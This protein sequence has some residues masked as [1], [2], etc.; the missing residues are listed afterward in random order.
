MFFARAPPVLP[1]LV[2]SLRV[3]PL[4]NP[5]TSLLRQTP[6]PAESRLPPSERQQRND[7]LCFT[8][9]WRAAYFREGTT[10]GQPG[11]PYVHVLI[12]VQFHH[13][14]FVQHQRKHRWEGSGWWRGGSVYKFRDQPCGVL[15]TYAHEFEV[16]IGGWTPQVWS[17]VLVN[18]PTS[19]FVNLLEGK[20]SLSICGGAKTKTKPTSTW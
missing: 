10:I 20:S 1:L 13:F 2:Q 3:A 15:Y 18:N 11:K 14:R 8:D 12:G 16:F 5:R 7:P 6:A 9:D 19:C 4:L 17:K